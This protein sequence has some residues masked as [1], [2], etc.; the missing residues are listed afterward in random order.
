MKLGESMTGLQCTFTVTGA[1]LTLFCPRTAQWYL[2]VSSRLATK[3]VFLTGCPSL[4]QTM[5][6]GVGQPGTQVSQT[7]S[8]SA[9]ELGCTAG[10]SSESQGKG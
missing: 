5:S 10:V 2:P 3:T 9:T 1:D 4:N 7:P 6:T 8:P